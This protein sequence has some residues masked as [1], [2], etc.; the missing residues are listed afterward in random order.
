MVGSFNIEKLN[1]ETFDYNNFRLLYKY[2]YKLLTIR[3]PNKPGT[4][5]SLGPTVFNI[6]IAKIRRLNVVY[7]TVTVTYMANIILVI[8]IKKK[9][10]LHQLIIKL[11]KCKKQYNN[12]L[13]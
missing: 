8:G 5:S 12:P 1:K 2:D 7:N 13:V 11:T 9:K 4:E 6:S 10:K 3:K